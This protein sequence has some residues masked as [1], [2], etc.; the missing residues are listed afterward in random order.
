MK[1]FSKSGRIV[2]KL[3][4]APVML[5]VAYFLVTSLLGPRVASASPVDLMVITSARNADHQ[6]LC[7]SPSAERPATICLVPAESTTDATKSKTPTN[8]DGALE[9]RVVETEGLARTNVTIVHSLEEWFEAVTKQGKEIEPISKIVFFRL[10]ADERSPLLKDWKSFENQLQVLALGEKTQMV[11]LDLKARDA[12]TDYF[13]AAVKGQATL[14]EQR[15]NVPGGLLDAFERWVFE[16]NPWALA[17][18]IFLIIAMLISSLFFGISKALEV[19]RQ[20]QHTRLARLESVLE[21]VDQVLSRWIEGRRGEII[22]K[23]N[24]RGF[25][26]KLQEVD[27]LLDQ[28]KDLK[29]GLKDLLD[30]E[31]YTLWHLYS[32][33]SS[34]LSASRDGRAEFTLIDAL[35][36]YMELREFYGNLYRSFEHSF[37]KGSDE[38]VVRELIGDRVESLV[39][40]ET[41][42]DHFLGKDSDRGAL[43]SQLQASAAVAGWIVGRSHEEPLFCDCLSELLDRS[44]S[45][46]AEL[47]QNFDD[48]SASLPERLNLLRETQKEREEQIKKLSD[49]LALTSKEKETLEALFDRAQQ[50]LPDHLATEKPLAE[51]INY[52]SEERLSINTKLAR[53][54]SDSSQP[55]SQQVEE[56]VTNLK[57]LCARFPKSGIPEIAWKDRLKEELAEADRRGQAVHDLAGELGFDSPHHGIETLSRERSLP[58]RHLRKLILGCLP[59]I[60]DLSMVSLEEGRKLYQALRLKEITSQADAFRKSLESMVDTQSLWESGL[61]PALRRGWLDNLL[62]ADLIVDTYYSD[63]HIG[64]SFGPIRSLAE[65]MRWALHQVEHSP[66]PIQLLRPIGALCKKATG[67]SVSTNLVNLEVVTKCIANHAAS[68]RDFVVDVKFFSLENHRSQQR[69]E[70]ILYNPADWDPSQRRLA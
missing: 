7:I 10:Q 69:C 14:E 27:R 57:E 70:V 66:C 18:I 29:R 24:D 4:V 40:L 36:E 31:P 5:P 21:G 34:Y 52:L 47:L 16:F 2:H 48:T 23:P 50:A 30:D 43:K 68:E 39:R 59:R 62:R 63:H 32:K 3:A 25:W 6:A 44:Q 38:R 28:V 8:S 60:E 12:F 64:E 55:L 37:P 56:I 15:R 45:L 13:Y 54:V 20:R 33:L 9:G 42:L 65:A 67:L 22:V 1:P 11:P 53:W 41:D 51:A 49:E 35:E 58:H 26:D 19:W 61:L 46:T 17:L